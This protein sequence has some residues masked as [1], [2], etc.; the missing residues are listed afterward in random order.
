MIEGLAD[1]RSRSAS[2]GLDTALQDWG[3]DSLS[4][5]GLLPLVKVLF[6]PFRAHMMFDSDSESVALGY[7]VSAFQAE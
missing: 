3:I 2:G 1:G 7:Y 6:R 4:H 5:R